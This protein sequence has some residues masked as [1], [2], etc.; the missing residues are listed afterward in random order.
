M[1][2]RRFF[3]KAAAALAAGETRDAAF[4]A[5]KAILKNPENPEAYRLMA[6][7]CE[8]AGSQQAVF[9]REKVATLL[10]S[11]A[12]ARLDWMQTAILFGDLVSAER[13][14]QTL[15]PADRKTAEF[16]K[17]AGVLAVAQRRPAI[18][19]TEFA[20][21]VRMQPSNPI[22][23]L[24]LAVLRLASSNA[25]VAADARATLIRLCQQ[26]AVRSD[27]LRHLTGDTLRHKRLNEALNYSQG[28]MQATNVTVPDRVLRLDVLL[29][30]KAP[31][32]DATLK[33]TQEAAKGVPAAAA[34][35]GR[36]M[37]RTGRA[38]EALVWLKSLSPDKPLTPPVVLVAVACYADLKDTDGLA[39][40]L[41]GGSWGDQDFYRE[42]LRSS[43][44]RLKGE[45]SAA[46]SAWRRALRDASDSREHLTEVIQF[47]AA[48][49]W[50]D[51][52]EE[53]L[54]ALVDRAPG[55]RW[56]VERLLAV[57]R[58]RG[59]TRRMQTLLSRAH[60]M[61]PT[62]PAIKNNLA[63][64]SLLLDARDSRGHQLASEAYHAQPTNAF[65]LS[66]YAF[67]LLQQKKPAQALKLFET[68]DRKAL[69]DP[70]VAMYYGLVLSGSGRGA[71]A[72]KYLAGSANAWLL[73]EE[74]NLVAMARKGT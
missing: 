22:P 57:Y 49:G 35:V 74:T 58:N 13:A 17:L 40:L 51:E 12:Q 55:E 62:N 28:L 9:Y 20:E 64:T 37:V 25:P 5:R 67:A 26:P 45:T 44:H 24:N 4:N 33:S 61:D 30:A 46:Q 56:A 59:K 43:V 6:Q 3:A 54:A 16:H 72:G 31:G 69:N 52:Q 23:Q 66:T 73:P 42:C 70:A 39:A 47:A 32:L 71:E 15:A 2:H 14:M 60:E 7:I 48:Q 18:A 68:L 1:Q 21:A 63:I 8:R 29:E 41:D 53:A 50:V 19:E 36:W 34:E 11:D 10:A 65:Y 27:A 38:K